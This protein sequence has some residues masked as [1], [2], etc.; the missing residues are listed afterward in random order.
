MRRRAL[1]AVLAAPALAQAGYPERPIRFIVPFP[2]AGGT[3]VISRELAG[4]LQADLG[5][6]IVIE[7]RPGAGGNIGLDTLAKAAPDG[8]TLGLGQTSN[9]AINPALYRNMPFDPLRDFALVSTVAQ[10]PLVLVTAMRAPFADLAAVVAA[11]RAP[12]ARLTAGHAG[13]GTVG[14]LAGELFARAAGAEITQVPYRGA[15]PVTT[16]MLARRVDIFFA[17]PPSVRGLIDAGE[18]RPLAVTSAMRSAA[19]PG[20]PT[21]VESGFPGV[22]AVNW[23]GVVAPARTPEAIV[24]R[25]S[26]AVRHAVTQAELAQKFTQ[27]GSEPLGSTPDTFRAF[28]TEET[29]KWGRLVREARIEM[30]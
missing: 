4:R 5:W 7:N 13:N 15:A 27:E 21:M 12:G 23:T 25:W 14:H 18:L 30:G 1:L 26:E 11:A 3:D 19:F 22:I 8:Y 24:T 6:N 20:I 10:Q 28:L 17:N 2:P 9:L 29:T 16:D